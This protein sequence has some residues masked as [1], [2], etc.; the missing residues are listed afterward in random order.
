MASSE[1]GCQVCEGLERAIKKADSVEVA[2]VFFW[3]APCHVR[4]VSDF[5]DLEAA[6]TRISAKFF[7]GLES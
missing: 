1:A 4:L 2:T 5:T 3:R 6:S 7:G